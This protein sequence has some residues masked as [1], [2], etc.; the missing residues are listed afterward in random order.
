M[1]KIVIVIPFLI[2]FIAALE[3]LGLFYSE[4]KFDELEVF[5]IEKKFKEND[6]VKDEVLSLEGVLFPFSKASILIVKSDY[7]HLD[8]IVKEVEW[9][10]DY[11]L[12]K[13]FGDSLIEK[14]RIRYQ[15]GSISEVCIYKSKEQAFQSR[16]IFF[17]KNALLRKK[18]KCTMEA[19]R[20]LDTLQ[21]A[22][23]DY[24]ASGKIAREKNVSKE[25]FFETPFHKVIGNSMDSSECKYHYFQNLIDTMDCNLFES[26]T[27]N[28]NGECTSKYSSR[29]YEF[30]YEK[31]GNLSYKGTVKCNGRKIGSLSV[32][33]EPGTEI[34]SLVLPNKKVLLE[35]DYS[36]PN[37]LRISVI[38]ESK[39]VIQKRE[40]LFTYNKNNLLIGYSFSRTFFDKIGKVNSID[41]SSI[42]KEEYQISYDSLSR[43][44]SMKHI[45]RN[46]Y[47][48]ASSFTESVH[49]YKYAE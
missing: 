42:Y 39:N 16:E 12:V 19:E 9:E 45:Q 38:S 32:K 48:S 23:Y 33:K 31:E 3:W 24:D 11:L 30:E 27:C 34:I 22:Y 18:I 14:K 28:D 40:K 15:N 41:S 4:K 26:R 35:K 21:R 2:F 20:C 10:N 17:Q 36:S 29:R 1:K 49:E 37:E 46:G 7:N 44:F 5:F 43:P 25:S 8:S 47:G 13:T 6:A